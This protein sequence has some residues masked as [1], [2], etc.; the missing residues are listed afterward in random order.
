MSLAERSYNPYIKPRLTLIHSSEKVG[1]DAFRQEYDRDVPPESLR[2]D[3]ESYLGEYR[4]QLQTY[5][6]ELEFSF[7]PLS[8]E[9]AL[10]D[11]D[12][13][14]PL[15]EMAKKA[16]KRREEEWKSTTREIA[17][18]QGILSLEEQIASASDGGTII[19][20]SPPGAKE[21]GYG[22]YGFVYIGRIQ[23][24][25]DS[26]GKKIRM[27][28]V[29]VENPSMH[30]Y[31]RGLTKLSGRL[32]PF[33]SSEQF[34]AT[35]IISENVVSNPEQILKDEFNFAVDPQ[36]EMIFRKVIRTLTP[37]INEFIS[38][39]K[40]G[41]PKQDLLRMFNAI[42]D[43]A[44]DLRTYYEETEKGDTNII[45]LRRPDNL[46]TFD[47][48]LQRYD[49]EPPE[50]LGSCGSSG[51]SSNIFDGF[52]SLKSILGYSER[53]DFI[54]PKCNKSSKPPVGDSCPKCGF[55]KKEAAKKG[56]K[57]C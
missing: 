41:Y 22:D 20:G 4:F 27:Q 49:Y 12:K 38:L 35:P 56:M 29:R 5:D 31:K 3:I 15:K 53:S 13:K 46:Q 18:Y 1:S 32:F 6:Y 21:D 37:R 50:V 16:I 23:T 8:N 55:T 39:V 44:L 43:Y 9:F 40:Q 42:E 54:C 36:K 57:V 19:W 30:Q 25:P 45:F 33:E 51:N 14:E 11:V 17:E 24:N 26:H 47:Q 7:D 48:M 28:A 52:S 2:K 10:R 34:L